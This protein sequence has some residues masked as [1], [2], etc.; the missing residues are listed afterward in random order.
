MKRF[1]YLLAC[2][3]F[4]FIPALL[5][6]QPPV[7]FLTGQ[8]A[9]ETIGQPTFTAQNVGN[10]SQDQL[11]SV[12]GLAYANN[13]LFVVDSNV[14]GLILPVN[15]RVMM[16]TN[17]S[18]FIYNPTA[19][20][21]QGS[22]CNVCVGTAAV[23][24]A[25]F[26]LGQPDFN[27]VTNPYTSQSG[28]RNPSYVATDGKIL[29]L[30]D[31]DNN[32]VLIWKTIPTQNNQP[33]DIVLG[34]PNFTSATV[35]LSASAMRGPQ[36][37][38]V[39]G[40]QLFVADTQNHR[41]LIWNSIPT[42]NNQPADLVL[43][44]PNFTTAP[45]Q[46]TADL[47]PTASNLFSPVAVTSDGQ[48]LIVTDLGH[49][50]VLIW[51]SIPTQNAQAADVVVGQPDMISELDNGSDG[52]CTPNGFDADGNPTY[53]NCTPTIC[54]TAGKDD[55]GTVLYQQR[56]GNVMEMPRYALSDGHRLFIADTG[57]DRVLI[58]STLP[59]TNG[60]KADIYLGQPD[61]FSDQVTTSTNTF[62]PD[63]NILESSA[64]TTRSPYGL[65]WDGTNLYVSDPFD[66]RVLVFTVGTPNIATNGVA[67]GAS[68]NTYAVGTV[69][70]TGTITAGDTASITIIPPGGSTG[71][72]YTYT[73]LKSDSLAS[74][75]IALAD[76]INSAP[77]PNV[78]ASANIVAGSLF[79]V[80]LVA[81]QPGL[82]GNNI[83]Y[84]ATTTPATSGGTPTEAATVAGSSLAGGA[85]AAELGAGT[86]VT[87][88]GNNLADTTEI[89]KPSAAGTYP[90]QLG[91]VEVYFDGIRSP[92]LFV[93]PK[94]INTQLPYEVNNANG[95]SAYVRTVH[96]DGSIT[97]TNAIG[98]PVVAGF[99]NPGIFALNTGTDP[100]PA[101]AYHTSGNAIAVVDV[102]GS[103]QA[104]DIATI[105]IKSNSY[106]YTVQSTDTLQSIRDGLIALINANP[107]EIVTAAPGGEFTRVVL[108]AKTGGPAGNGIPIAGAVSSNATVTVSPL[109]DAVTCCANVQG[110]LITKDNPLV[111]GEVITIYA[112]GIGPTTLADGLTIA[113]VTGQSYPGPLLNI[114]VTNVDNAQ[115][116]G[117]T[118]NVISAGL[119]VGNL[120][121]VY[122]VV[123][124][125]QNTLPTNSQT[126]MYIA[127]NVFT[128]NIVT[129][130]VVAQSPTGTT[131]AARAAQTERP[132]KTS[133][134]T[135]KGRTSR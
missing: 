133:R 59:T 52:T 91:G 125:T 85:A 24:N 114:P 38:W 129:V 39:Q 92:V 4:A 22:R 49:H 105:K 30:S 103:A 132:A 90:T 28:F 56:C 26:V 101:L 47:P 58:Y 29:V 45:P 68:L 69:S 48:R 35:G 89:A 71:T 14:H 83:G 17:I 115:I 66:V 80:N 86:L 37:V 127:Q 82:N 73:V 5:A 20:V 116:G 46:T 8:A 42:A 62:R 108:T 94:Q 102:S 109:G 99:G 44:E 119:D 55:I 54:P 121:G 18:R 88:F 25:S 112:T 117:T 57:N 43:G 111:P 67:N 1:C 51:N 31:T 130:P 97:A 131:P 64:D 124:Q 36:G 21:P 93:S 27:T 65:A 79:V 2:I 6:Q 76:K 123:L 106:N 70:L 23:G 134:R 74:I 9:R 98:V 61:E 78:I 81:R 100:R 96:H 75:I 128:S 95:V 87:I 40:N 10:P 12:Q 13:M 50:R 113:S 60:A 126:Q 19:E 7:D 3:L 72:T 34:Q 110:S 118:A 104:G 41:V 63:A 77:D 15:N 135:K 16:Y 122:K 120:P 11:G 32:R 53:P 84:S 33:A 107:D